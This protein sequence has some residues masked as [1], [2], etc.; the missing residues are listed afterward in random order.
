MI[1][2]PPSRSISVKQR[3]GRS[4]GVPKI[5]DFGQSGDPKCLN[6]QISATP[7]VCTKF[8]GRFAANFF[9]DFEQFINSKIAKFSRAYGAI[10]TSI[11]CQNRNFSRAYGAFYHL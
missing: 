8:S 11:R 2:P 10:L 3:G 4:L 9:G 6:D 1:D 7:S 5:P